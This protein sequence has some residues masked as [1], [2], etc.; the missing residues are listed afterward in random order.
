MVNPSTVLNE[1]KNRVRTDVL[2]EE[3][4][5]AIANAVAAY[6]NSYDFKQHVQSIVREG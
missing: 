2:T 1:I 6:L 5:R 4:M 3:Q